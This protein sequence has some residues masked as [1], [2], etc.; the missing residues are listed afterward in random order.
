MTSLPQTFS[1]YAIDRRPVA[2]VSS[3]LLT[4]SELA[5][6]LIGLY[7]SGFRRFVVPTF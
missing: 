2:D 7:D 3:I 1:S 6:I 4:S 5:D